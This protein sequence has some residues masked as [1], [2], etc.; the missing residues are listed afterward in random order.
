MSDSSKW[1]FLESREPLNQSNADLRSAKDTLALIHE[2]LNHQVYYGIDYISPP[3][4][5]SY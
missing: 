4:H 2:Q 3:F 1:T 5:L